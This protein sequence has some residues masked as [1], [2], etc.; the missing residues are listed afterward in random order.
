M[1][2]LRWIL[3][4]LF[5][6]KDDGVGPK[7]M[8]LIAEPRRNMEAS[9]QNALGGLSE[10][11]AFPLTMVASHVGDQHYLR[12]PILPDNSFEL[13]GSF[14]RPEVRSG[15]DRVLCRVTVLVRRVFGGY[16]FDGVF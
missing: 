14:L 15:E 9:L 5:G 2:R 16:A 13:F 4:K 1:S 10:R 6:E 12:V 11:Q 8:K 7:K 3:V